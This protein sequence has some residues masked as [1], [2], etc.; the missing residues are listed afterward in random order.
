MASHKVSITVPSTQ[1]A[2]PVSLHTHGKPDFQDCGLASPVSELDVNGIMRDSAYALLWLASLAQHRIFETQPY[3]TIA[4]VS[5]FSLSWFP[6]CK[7]CLQSLHFAKKLKFY[8]SAPFIEYF[9]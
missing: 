9:D 7:L 5:S 6:I 1:R 4:V 2:C 8:F 3:C